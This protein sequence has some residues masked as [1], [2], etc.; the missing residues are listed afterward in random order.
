M[1][2][3]RECKLNPVSRY[4]AR[5]CKE[6]RKKRDRE[7]QERFKAKHPHRVQEIRRRSHLFQNYRMSVKEYAVLYKL[8]KG[9]CSICGIEGTD[10]GAKEGILHIDHS[11]TTGAI[12]GLLCRSCNL[13]LGFFEDNTARLENAI[14]YLVRMGK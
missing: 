12:R 7:A 1:N 9:L 14:G 2:V 4:N 3:C 11:H 10:V 6:C 5:Y 13:G 8:H